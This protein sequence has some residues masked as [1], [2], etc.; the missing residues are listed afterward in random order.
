LERERRSCIL[1]VIAQH[2]IGH[3]VSPGVAEEYNDRRLILRSGK[4][5]VQTFE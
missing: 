5:V 2:D 3:E 4:K 1:T